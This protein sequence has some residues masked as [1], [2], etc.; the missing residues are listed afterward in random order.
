MT[1]SDG[2]LIFPGRIRVKQ[3]RTVRVAQLYKLLHFHC[4]EHVVYHAYV[5]HIAFSCLHT[6]VTLAAS[7]TGSVWLRE[8]WY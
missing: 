8:K 3:R 1:K 4:T 2:V 6:N 5:T 7:F